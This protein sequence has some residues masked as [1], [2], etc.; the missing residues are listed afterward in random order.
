MALVFMDSFDHYGNNERLLK[1]DYITNSGLQ[2]TAAVGRN[3]T[4]GGRSVAQNGGANATGLILTN[5]ATWI[6]GFAF[7]PDGFPT[8]QTALWK[9]R[10]GG[11]AGTEQFSVE[12]TSG[13]FFAVARGGTI[14]AT[15]TSQITAG[16]SVH[17][18]L[19]VVIGNTGSYELRINSV[20]VLS[21]GSVD[22]QNSANAFANT[23]EL[24]KDAGSGVYDFD[25]YWL[26]DGNNSGVSG[27]PNDDFLGDLRIQYRAPNGNG[28]SSGM[29]GSDGN[30]TDN[31][32]LVDEGTPN[33]D[34]DYVVGDSVGDK[35]TYT[36]ADL[37]PTAGTVFGVQ[38]LSSARKTDAG[39]R[40]ICNVVRSASVEEDSANY[41][42]STDYDYYRDLRQD[43]PSNNQWTVSSV[44]AMEI[45]TKVTV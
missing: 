25:D 20:N 16:L 15:S 9:C 35:D 44:N 3:G 5:Q 27:A 17:V 2:P 31:Y 36:V 32:L 42:L 19:K 45:G 43:D 21:N 24:G 40:S 23:V 8:A 12:L 7:T 22:T 11:Q 33:G 30:S 10:D 37:T 6:T 18:Q 4:A 38:L 29:V 13:G 34:T 1:Y 39:A 26:C 41:S 28:N 14:I